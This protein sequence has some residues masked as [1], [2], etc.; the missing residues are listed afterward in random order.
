MMQTVEHIH[1]GDVPS[2]NVTETISA[3]LKGT[4]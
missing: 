1:T 2:R 3:G 4:V